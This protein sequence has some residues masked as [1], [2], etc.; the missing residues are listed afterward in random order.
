MLRK[1]LTLLLL[2]LL[3][4]CAK[5]ENEFRNE[6]PDDHL[7]RYNQIQVKGTHNSYHIE[8]P[9]TSKSIPEYRYTHKP[10]NDQLDHGVRQI[11][12]DIHYVEDEGLKVYH[13]PYIDSLSTCGLFRECLSIV[14]A[15]S[16]AHPEHQAIL[17]FIEPKDD[18]D[19]VKL[20]DKFELVESDILSVFPKSR[21]IK[22]DDVRGDYPTLR[23]AI[24]NA[25]WP[26][27][28]ETRGKVLFH[29]NDSGDFRESYLN[30][31]P[32]LKGALM[33]VDS[34]PEDSFA[35]IMPMNNPV[36]DFDRIQSAVKQGF[37]VRT[38]A[39]TC[40]DEAINNDMSKVDAAL[41]SGAHFISTDFPEPVEGYDFYVEIPGGTP[42]R[43]N[44]LTAPDFCEPGDIEKIGIINP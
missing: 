11:E 6:Y 12:L 35:A 28:A 22:P 41:S 37:L 40:C 8:D 20:Y 42:S 32:D 1:L 25:G 36:G 14:K 13:L 31:H 2:I 18:I 24:I 27:L 43:C 30:A 34:T 17:I 39:G 21:I 4:T 5:K 7:L 15:W 33:F 26:T 19:P 29:V 23:E 44:P 38:M 3:V 16:D 10:L 9:T